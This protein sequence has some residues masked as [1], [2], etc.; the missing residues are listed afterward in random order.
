MLFSVSI[1]DLDQ[2]AEKTKKNLGSK[3]LANP[4]KTTA[5]YETCIQE[6]FSD[7]ILIFTRV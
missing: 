4:E 7:Q 6:T 2:T 3:L 1:K 5:N